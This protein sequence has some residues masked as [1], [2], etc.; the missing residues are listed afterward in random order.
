MD[1]TGSDEKE[2]FTI[3]IGNY[4][5]TLELTDFNIDFNGSQLDADLLNT[6]PPGNI[7]SN[8]INYI[9]SGITLKIETIPANVEVASN[10]FKWLFSI[11]AIPISDLSNEFDI[12]SGTVSERLCLRY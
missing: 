2:T 6:Q 4:F 3:N 8:D 5:G 9:T 7:I 1:N 12:I 11:N 10:D